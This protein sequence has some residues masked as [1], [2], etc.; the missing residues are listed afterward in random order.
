[1]T[2]GT[3]HGAAAAELAIFLPFLGFMFVVA[4]DYC[5]FFHYSQT[6]QSCAQA[7]A[8]YWSGHAGQE[9]SAAEAAQQ[10]AVAEGASLNPPLKAEQVTTS[11]SAG[12]A[13]VTVQYDFQML[14]PLWGKGGKVTLTRSVQ[15]SPAPKLPGQ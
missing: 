14:T 6:I 13:I 15:M 7:A 10:A 3:R 1:M 8:M 4:V 11:N 5:R 12:M 9:G 2:N